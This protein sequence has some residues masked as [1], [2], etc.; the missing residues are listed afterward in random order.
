MQELDLAQ[1]MG[2]TDIVAMVAIGVMAEVFRRSFVR[3]FFALAIPIGIG[4]LYGV[5]IALGD[6]GTAVDVLKGFLVNGAAATLIARFVGPKLP[7]LPG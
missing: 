4:G 6:D 5:L 3:K 1:L 2:G 7:E